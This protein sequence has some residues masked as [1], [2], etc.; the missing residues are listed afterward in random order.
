M[1]KK[2]VCFD[3]VSLDALNKIQAKTKE[4]KSKIIRRLLEQEQIYLFKVQLDKEKNEDIPNQVRY[5]PINSS[6]K[7]S[8]CLENNA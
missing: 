2:L 6:E 8:L 5:I 4:N 7:E 3:S 1:I